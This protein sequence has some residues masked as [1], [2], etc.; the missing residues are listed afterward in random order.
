MVYSFLF[1]SYLPSLLAFSFPVASNVPQASTSPNLNPEF[2]KSCL[3]TFK[4]RTNHS[5]VSPTPTLVSSP[6][7]S[8]FAEL[9][10][11]GSGKT[12]DIKISDAS[13]LTNHYPAA[14]KD[15][16]GLPSNPPC[17]YKS[18]PA[19][20]ERTGSYRIIH[21]VRPVYDYP[22]ADQW[23]ASIVSARTSASSSTPRASN[24]LR[25]TLS[26][27][28]KRGVKPF[29][30]LLTWIGVYPKF[31]LYNAAAAEAIKEIL[32][33][34]GFPEIE[35]AFRESVVT[36]SVALGSKLLSFD[37]LRDPVPELLKPFTPTLGL[38]IAPLRTPYYEGTGALYLRVS[39]AN[40]RTI[41]LTAAHVA[42]PPPTLANTD[43][44]RRRNS[45]AAEEI[46]ALGDKGYS[47]AV[48]SM[49]SAIDD[50][51]SSID[52][53]NDNI[54]RSSEPTESEE[55]DEETTDKRQEY[56]DLVDRAKK[57]IEEINKLHSEVTR[58]RTTPGAAHHRFCPPRRTHR[59]QRWT[60]PVHPRLGADE[61]Y[62]EK[63][64]WDSFKG[65]KIYI[66]TFSMSGHRIALQF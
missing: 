28:P 27:L 36:R 24:G 42:R 31:L 19:W 40:K 39:N 25:S 61:L 35:V 52:I 23:H 63:I 65:N 33:Q 64:D 60:P 6:M 3:A 1:L 43:M 55:E 5:P 51:T 44:S 26:L 12:K 54:A 59:R 32:A 21:E 13:R 15:F 34:A 2:L 58:F 17:V 49:L 4:N 53:W 7:A 9:D 14:Y 48:T 57:K 47:N 45:Q 50:L 10:V 8:A 62:E 56:L 18:G 16:Y 37:P 11:D 29:C 41:L 22:I 30:P 20:R 66:G 46:V 38:S